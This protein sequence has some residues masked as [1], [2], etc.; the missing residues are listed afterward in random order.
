[1]IK[2]NLPKILVILGPTATGKTSLAV[3]LANE[4]NGELISADAFQIYKEL[5]IGTNKPTLVEQSQAKFHLISLISIHE[6]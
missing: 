1:M 3:K 6:S 2:N 5:N 4:L